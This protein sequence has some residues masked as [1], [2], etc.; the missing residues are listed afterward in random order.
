MEFNAIKAQSRLGLLNYQAQISKYIYYPLKITNK[1]VVE[2]EK[3]HKL[4]T[5]MPI[6]QLQSDYLPQG[7]HECTIDEL[8]K[9]FFCLNDRRKTLLNNLE[10]YISI[11]HQYGL[12]GWIILDGSFVTVKENPGDID[13]ILVISENQH[14][15][16]S[17]PVTQFDLT[18]LR[19]DYV[20][21][22]FELHLFV[23][24]TD[25]KST[26]GFDDTSNLWIEFFKGIRGNANMKKGLL[27]VRI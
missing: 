6:P 4:V 19:K 9:S 12:T 11:L 20:K 21:K 2:S 23:G 10:K 13:I 5:S 27:M 26:N 25:A 18:M 24:F 16:V 17:S 1:C 15:S 7:V 8:R 22:N 3:F 14:Y